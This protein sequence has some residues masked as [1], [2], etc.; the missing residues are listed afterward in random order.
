MVTKLS[1]S[2][3]SL[4]SVFFFFKFWGCNFINIADGVSFSLGLTV[5]SF[6]VIAEEDL[7]FKARSGAVEFFKFS[8]LFLNIS[9]SV[10]VLKMRPTFCR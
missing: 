3:L 1:L 2:N 10:F 6:A 4:P 5:H 7:R 9:Y 8:W